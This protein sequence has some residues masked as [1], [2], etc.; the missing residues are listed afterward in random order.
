M[1]HTEPILVA[2]KAS[3]DMLR[4]KQTRSTLPPISYF[5]EHDVCTDPT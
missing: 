1:T 2:I 3:A 4:G 5:S